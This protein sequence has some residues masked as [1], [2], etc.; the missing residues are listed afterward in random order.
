V[1]FPRDRRVSREFDDAL[2]ERYGGLVTGDQEEPVLVGDR[3]LLAAGQPDAGGAVRPGAEELPR[4]ER[5]V[6]LGWSIMGAAGF[7]PVA[8]GDDRG[9]PAGD[10]GCRAR[11]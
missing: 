1:A 9:G 4:A 8:A 7:E 2:E 3:F 6:M 10:A 5:D 11:P